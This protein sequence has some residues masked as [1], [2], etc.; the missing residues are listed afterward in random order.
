MGLGGTGRGSPETGAGT[1]SVAG[2][3]NYFANTGA[4]SPWYAGGTWPMAVYFSDTDT[5]WFVWEAKGGI[6]TRQRQVECTTFN[7]T[8]RLWTPRVVV[9]I[10]TITDDSH[11]V[12]SLE[13]DNSGYVYCWY[14]AHINP[15]QLSSTQLPN[16]PTVWRSRTAISSNNTYP[17][18]WLVGSTFYLFMRDSNDGNDQL[19]TLTKSTALT[20]GVPT[21]GSKV[22]IVDFD[23][24]SRVY[25]TAGHKL[26]TDIH[27]TC[28]RA[29]SGDSERR[30]V[31][32]FVYDT[33]TGNIRNF[34]NTVTVLAASFP[35][36]YAQA[37]ASF[38]IYTHAVGHEGILPY[39]Q[40]DTN[41]HPHI[42]FV[43]GVL[44]GDNVNFTGPG[45]T[46]YH[47]WH[48]GTAWQT[49]DAT[50]KYMQA[51]Y[52]SYAIHRKAAGVMGITW[53]QRDGGSWDRDG[54]VYTM[55]RAVDGGYS[56]ATRV[57]VATDYEL[58]SVAAVRDGKSECRWIFTERQ[59]TDE[60]APVGTLKA[61][62][63]GDGGFLKRASQASYTWVN[64]QGAA[65]NARR[66][67][68][69]SYDNCYYID[70]LFTLIV[71][72][73]ISKFD[74]FYIATDN[75]AD[76]LLNLI[77]A[78]YPLVKTGTANFT[79]YAGWLGDGSTGYLSTGF[80]P[81]SAG[82]A[83][84]QN[85][86]HISAWGL[87]AAADAVQ[88]I[89]ANDGTRLSFIIPGLSAASTTWRMNTGTSDTVASTGTSGCFVA[90]RSAAGA[91]QLYKNGVSVDSNTIPSTGLPQSE[92]QILHSGVSGVNF[93][94]NQIWT[95]HG[96]SSLT[97][98]EASDLQFVGQL[99]LGRVW[100]IL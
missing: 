3:L 78:S 61:Y 72:I 55:D 56:T 73:G 53:T 22:Q 12:P 43:D 77:S 70:R 76:S 64:A 5:T 46:L 50:G 2:G 69:L 75:E 9:G 48:N 47:V 17:H 85:S 26:G 58:G 41:D 11:G 32:H 59:T 44:S 20:A 80:I 95:V 74:F 27:F 87:L 35:V 51:R 24:D 66:A 39:M 82:G 89:A 92:I 1:R 23:P 4:T 38:R 86:A 62:A 14:G 30:H 16:D 33:V 31:Y 99:P 63:Y 83:M 37:N 91:Q 28:A 94:T 81:S 90:N 96:G 29:D 42:L 49:P 67:K 8:T 13:R 25:E 88:T 68:P 71:S 36:T 57:A 7:H 98:T 52:D 60:T 79:Q 34:D 100:G 15:M 45:A 18:C 65:Y 40:F 19:L 93:S 97:A 10:L 21:W 84:T 6:A 54:N